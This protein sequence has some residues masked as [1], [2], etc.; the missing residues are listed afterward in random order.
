MVLG[1]SLNRPARES[2]QLRAAR[3]RDC[4]K[5]DDGVAVRPTRLSC[6]CQVRI[7]PCAELS[8]HFETVNRRFFAAYEAVARSARRACAALH[9]CAL[10]TARSG[11]RAARLA[12]CAARSLS[13]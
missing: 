10:N 11:A 3:A 8:S 2:I 13:V 9:A 4:D 6:R 12:D 7:E 1:P 5:R